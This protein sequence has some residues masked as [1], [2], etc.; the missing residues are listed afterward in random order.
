MECKGIEVL[1]ARAIEVRTLLINYSMEDSNGDKRQECKCPQE[2]NRY[3]MQTR[4]WWMYKYNYIKQ[5]EMQNAIIIS[6]MK[7]YN[8]S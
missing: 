3:D 4:L 5:D 1:S 6:K 2:S 7:C 8:P